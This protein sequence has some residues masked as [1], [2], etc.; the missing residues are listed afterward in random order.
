MAG[1]GSR[2]KSLVSQRW[3][4]IALIGITAFAFLLRF[5]H[6]FGS[7][8]YIV[9]PDSYYFHW[10]SVKY[11]AGEPIGLTGSGLVLPLV[12]LSKGLSLLPGLS[13]SESPW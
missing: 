2:L 7:S 8:Y 9:S 6:L 1:W 5:L 11:T 10:L 4:L 12:Y 3:P 13:T